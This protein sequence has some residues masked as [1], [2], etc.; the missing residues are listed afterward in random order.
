[1][2]LLPAAAQ[3]H[4]RLGRRRTQRRSPRQRA[5]K[6]LGDVARRPLTPYD[7]RPLIRTRPRI[8]CLPIRRACLAP[9]FQ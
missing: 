7:S 2:V 3:H 6:P 1:M 9:V 4:S 5:G 8:A